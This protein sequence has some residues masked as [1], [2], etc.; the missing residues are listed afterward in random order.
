MLLFNNRLLLN[1]CFI[2]CTFSVEHGGQNTSFVLPYTFSII[3]HLIN[4]PSYDDH[5]Y[6]DYSMFFYIVNTCCGF[7]TAL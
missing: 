7:G 2:R 3:D 4:G 1:C 5:I 6:Y